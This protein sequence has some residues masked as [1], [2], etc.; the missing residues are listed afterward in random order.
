MLRDYKDMLKLLE[1][2]QFIN[3]NSILLKGKVAR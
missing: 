1:E 2:L 3:K